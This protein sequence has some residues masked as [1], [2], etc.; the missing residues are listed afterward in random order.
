ML[1][2]GDVI[3]SGT[4]GYPIDFGDGAVRKPIPT[5][6]TFW[7]VFWRREPRA[8]A[9]DSRISPSSGTVV[10]AAPD[11]TLWLAGDTNVAVQFGWWPTP[12]Q[13]RTRSVF[14]S[15]HGRRINIASY[16]IASTNSSAYVN[17]IARRCGRSN[18]TRWRSRRRH[19]LW[20]RPDARGRWKLLILKQA[21]N[22]LVRW[23][24]RFCRIATYNNQ[25]A[26]RRC[27]AKRTSARGGY[28]GQAS[29]VGSV[30]LSPW[31]F[32][33]TATQ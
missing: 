5:S 30:T 33:L 4:G 15:L 21:P 29:T 11:G 32:L 16:V 20:S 18:R 3:V 22:G 10:T 19:E 9:S 8:G 24:H 12:I 7:S 31:G 14:R 13:H 23:A 2:D 17:S 28:V 1:P 6:D 27:R 26:G 25:V